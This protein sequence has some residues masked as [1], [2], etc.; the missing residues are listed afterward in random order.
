MAASRAG[1]AALGVAIA[2]CGLATVF[3]QHSCWEGMCPHSPASGSIML[4]GLRF[5]QRD[6]DMPVTLLR[7]LFALVP[8][9]ILLSGSAVLFSRRKTVWTFLQLLGAGGLLLVALT[10][11]FEALHV[12]TWMHWGVEHSL[13]HYLDLSSA[14]LGLT[15][16][17]AGYLLHSLAKQRA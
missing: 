13:G 1:A 3:L 12:F 6:H 9:C 2:F 14:V 4:G 15:L 7:G 5:N 16:F 17:P 10:H 8:T 11:I